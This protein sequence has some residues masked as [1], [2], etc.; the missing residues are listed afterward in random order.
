MQDASNKENLTADINLKNSSNGD[1]KK[2]L[3]I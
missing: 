3:Y 2:L 1:T